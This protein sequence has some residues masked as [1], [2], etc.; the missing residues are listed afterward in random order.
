M[1]KYRVTFKILNAVPKV[2]LGDH[3]SGILIIPRCKIGTRP[4]P[5]Q[6]EDHYMQATESAGI[7]NLGTL[8]DLTTTSE[9]TSTKVVASTL[10]HVP[11][12]SDGE[13]SR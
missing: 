6:S 3:S 11:A 2:T 12:S 9:Y 13:F 4:W 8:F 5:G 7:Q 1:E 10:F